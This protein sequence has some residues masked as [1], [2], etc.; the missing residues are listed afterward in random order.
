VIEAHPYFDRLFEK[1]ATS[2]RRTRNARTKIR[3]VDEIARLLAERAQGGRLLDIGAGRGFQTL[4]WHDQLPACGPA[5]I[6]DARDHRHSDVVPQTEFRQV[7]LDGGRFPHADETF[8]VA[9]MN[10]LLVTLKD[11][12]TPVAES[13]RVLKPGGLFLV[14]VPN[15]AALHNS[16]LLL[17][18]LQPTT[19]HIGGDHV[20][21][22]ALRS[23]T[24]FL[25]QE[26]RFRVLKT[27]GIGVHPFT[28]A[29][30][31]EPFRTYSHTILWL[32]QKVEV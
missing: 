21:G 10:Q 31:P 14:S 4:I 28:S 22:F 12:R 8:D 18:G 23:M 9:V 26:G 16:A 17:L 7:D 20:R 2:V 6:Y 11:V 1:P 24:S 29:V 5:V 30:V 3:V 32:L 27:R 19:L 25:R 15:L 13:W